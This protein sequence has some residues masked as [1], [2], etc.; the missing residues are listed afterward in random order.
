[1]LE[2]NGNDKAKTDAYLKEQWG[3]DF[4][5]NYK[6]YNVEDVYAGKYHGKGQDKTAQI[7]KYLSKMIKDGKKER[8]G[9]VVVDKELAELLQ[10]LMDKYTFENVDQS[11]LKL[12]YYYDHMG[13]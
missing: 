4:E 7:K 13:K 12:C 11:W 8:E 1:M 5:A 9:C 3:E 2:Q 10:L 6:I